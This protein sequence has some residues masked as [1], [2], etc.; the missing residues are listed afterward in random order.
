MDNGSLE[1]AFSNLSTPLI[2]DACVR[3]HVP[4][5]VAPS[6]IH[7][8]VSDMRVAGRV[9]PARHRGSV[10]VFLEAMKKALPGDVLVVDNDGRS[11]ESCVGDLTVIEARAWGVAGLVVRGY[12][13]DTDELVRLGFPVFSYGSYPAGPLR[14]DQRGPQDLSSAQWGGF[15]VDGDDVVFADV[16]GVLFV[17]GGKVEEVLEAAK[18]IW[19]VERKQAETIQAGRKLSE[20]LDFDGYL[21]K[22]SSDP[23]YTFRRHLRERGGAVEE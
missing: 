2:A 12:H 6:G 14:L 3:L 21:A 8:L 22:R 19:K 4:L 5:R 13:R 10:D 9:L 17:P 20:Q 11:D 15:T 1:S 23:S 7:P 18:S 16:D